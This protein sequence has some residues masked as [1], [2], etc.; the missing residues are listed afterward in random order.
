ME[1]VLE[2]KAATSAKKSGEALQVPPVNANA[3]DYVQKAQK[4]RWWPQMLF[5][6][7]YC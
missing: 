5:S 4:T 1:W 2:E 7:R 3:F 6:F